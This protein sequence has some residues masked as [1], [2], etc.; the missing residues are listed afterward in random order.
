MRARSSGRERA[1]AAS[2]DSADVAAGHGAP[3]DFPRSPRDVHESSAADGDPRLEP[4][5]G[6]TD[7]WVCADHP[8]PRWADWAG[9]AWLEWDDPRVCRSSPSRL[10]PGSAPEAPCELSAHAA[11]TAP[12]WGSAVPRPAALIGGGGSFGPS[13]P[14]SRTAV[15]LAE[16]CGHSPGGGDRSG[17]GH[18]S[19]TGPLAPPIAAWRRV[20][21]RAVASESSRSGADR[22]DNLY[23]LLRD[24]WRVDRDGTRPVVP[25]HLCDQFWAEVAIAKEQRRARDQ[26]TLAQRR[27]S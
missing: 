21:Q 18:G 6:H 15:A 14:I 22:I 24:C 26:L 7:W 11:G 4:G 27:P 2:D 10:P 8:K 19:S 3:S 5:H 13:L 20:V 9:A 16:A 1:N 25:R 12:K 23:G 17:G